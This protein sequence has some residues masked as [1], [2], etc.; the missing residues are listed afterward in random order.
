MSRS[1]PIKSFEKNLQALEKLVESMESGELSLDEALTQ[2]EKGVR[3]TRDCQQALTSAE[4]RVH[5]VLEENGE[6]EDLE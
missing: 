2:F 6:L 1:N 4:Q 5:K 3:M